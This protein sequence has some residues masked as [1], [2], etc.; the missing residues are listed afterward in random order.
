MLTAMWGKVL[1]YTSTKRN[2]GWYK[3]LYDKGK[4]NRTEIG[5]WAQ[6][7]MRV[8]EGESWAGP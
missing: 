2:I 4:L 1:Y 6:W 7:A 5:A 3:E 8:K